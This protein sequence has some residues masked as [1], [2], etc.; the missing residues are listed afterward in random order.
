[1]R[2]V[3]QYADACDDAD[4]A[5]DHDDA[6]DVQEDMFTSGGRPLCDPNDGGLAPGHCR[7]QPEDGHGDQTMRI[8]KYFANKS[9]I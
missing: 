5:L 2:I 1:M 4:S 8:V 6:D 9:K 7:D 3:A